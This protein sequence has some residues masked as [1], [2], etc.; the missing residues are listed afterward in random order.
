MFPIAARIIKVLF[1]IQLVAK[2]LFF[3]NLNRLKR[4]VGTVENKFE[5]SK[6]GFNRGASLM[7]TLRFELSTVITKP[8][9]VIRR[10]NQL[11]KVSIIVAQL[12]KQS[13]L[14]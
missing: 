6:R 7:R 12:T 1:Y 3:F 8:E 10:S 11:S 4:K 5:L 13:I 2:I 9:F 14:F